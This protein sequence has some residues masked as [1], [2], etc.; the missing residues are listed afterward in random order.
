LPFG[1][2]VTTGP[3]GRFE[4]PGLF[5]GSYQL[6]A[7]KEGCAGASRE[8]TLAE[9]EEITD[10]FLALAPLE[11]HDH[12]TAPGLP[13]PDNDPSGVTSSIDIASDVPITEVAVFIDITHT[14][15]GDL[16]IDLTSPAGTTVRLHSFGGGSADDLVGWFPDDLTPVQSLDAFLAQNPAGTW[17]LRVADRGPYDYGT[18]NAWG[19]RLAEPMDITEVSDEGRELPRAVALEGNVPNPFNP[20]TEIRFGLPRECNVDLSVFDLRGRR[21]AELIDDLLPAGHHAVAWDGTD[22]AGGRVASGTYF[23]RLRADGR[24]L[25]R[26][27][28]MIK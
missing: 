10:L 5:A 25:V 22:D 11:D 1:Q 20:R 21:V 2:R 28:N 4:F 27:L 9:G 19:I 6:L 18:L 17:T 8:F 14:Y 3:D 13:I 15:I 7:T 26:K 23:C 12:L 16:V 24:T